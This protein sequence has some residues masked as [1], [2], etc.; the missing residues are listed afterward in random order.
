MATNNRKRAI[1]INRSADG[2]LRGYAGQ[3]RRKRW[4]R[5]HPLCVHCEARHELTVATE[6]DH[7]IALSNGGADD[8]SNLQSLCH[9]CHVAKTLE[10]LNIKPRSII[11]IDGYVQD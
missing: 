7:V 10:D 3:Q 8:T 4:L 2:R 5:N 11:G 6:V 1:P 9:V